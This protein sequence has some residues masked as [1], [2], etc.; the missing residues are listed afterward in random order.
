MNTKPGIK[1][2]EFWVTLLQ[3]LVGPVVMILIAAGIF[4][5]D[6]DQTVVTNDLTSGLQSL[7]TA[8]GGIFA[9]ITS[10]SAV[11]TYTA[12]RATVKGQP[13]A[14]KAA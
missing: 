4:N 7:A 5:A 12:S 2:T 10:S 3:A 6:V 1:T 14:D 8:A 11:K 13:V 9:V